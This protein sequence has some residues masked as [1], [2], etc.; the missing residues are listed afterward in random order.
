MII[1]PWKDIRRYIGCVPGLEE[2]IETVE[3]LKQIRAKLAV[4]CN[5]PSNLLIL[6]EPTNHLDIKAQKAL[7]E[8]IANYE[9][10][11]ILVSHEEDF[12]LDLC[13][14]VTLLRD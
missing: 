9:G 2:A 10:A 7:R 8:A 11:L 3:N 12:A 1:C 5:T 4:L 14:S 6:D 13:D